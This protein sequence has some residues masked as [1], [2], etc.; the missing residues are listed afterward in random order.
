MRQINN[1]VNY[2][3][4]A[5]VYHRYTHVSP[6]MEEGLLIGIA[7]VAILIVIG[8]IFGVFDWIAESFSSLFDQF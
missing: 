5:R 1:I 3:K 4:T 6:I 7:I 2:I 8:L